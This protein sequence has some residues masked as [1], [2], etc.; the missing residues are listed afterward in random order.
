MQSLARL[1]YTAR[2][3]KPSLNVALKTALFATGKRQQDI[4]KKARIEPQKLSHAIHGK[5]ELDDD[6]KCR[7]ARVLGKSED[8][9]F[10]VSA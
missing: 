6:E 9:L 1:S 3:S 8:E 10:A 4:A 5:R 2:M 7:L